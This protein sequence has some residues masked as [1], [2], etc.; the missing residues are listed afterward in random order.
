M[1]EIY[2]NDKKAQEEQHQKKLA[3]K[4]EELLKT[5]QAKEAAEQLQGKKPHADPFNMDSLIANAETKQNGS[6]PTVRGT[7]KAG[8]EHQR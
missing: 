3:A 5:R 7:K 4:R 6:A 8:T 2:D 1:N